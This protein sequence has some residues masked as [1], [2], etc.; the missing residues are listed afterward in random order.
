MFCLKKLFKHKNHRKSA[1]VVPR[2]S[3]MD[4]D[5]TSNLQVSKTNANIIITDRTS[6]GIVFA[7]YIGHVD[8]MIVEYSRRRC[9][10]CFLVYYIILLCNM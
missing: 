9:Y 7:Y 8:T 10:I 2:D 5:D 1:P 3:R 4:V 6:I